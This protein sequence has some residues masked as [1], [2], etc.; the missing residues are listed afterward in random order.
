[1]C[2]C[3]CVCVCVCMYIYI[4]MSSFFFHLTHPKCGSLSIQVYI[5]DN[6]FL[7]KHYEIML[8]KMLNIHDWNQYASCSVSLFKYHSNV[9]GRSGDIWPLVSLC[10]SCPLSFRAQWDVCRLATGGGRVQP[11][12]LCLCV[13][14]CVW[15]R[16]RERERERDGT[17]EW[18]NRASV[19]RCRSCIL[20]HHYEP[21]DLHTQPRLSPKLHVHTDT[22][23]QRLEH[24]AGDTWSFHFGLVFIYAFIYLF[25]IIFFSKCII[26]NNYYF[27]EVAELKNT[28]WFAYGKH[29]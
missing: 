5:W 23:Q 6:L 12:V 21:T 17:V 29:A 11:S 10:L 20:H 9:N 4:Y 25:C 7:I 16:E 19:W 15:E 27:T 13:C 8:S 1:M 18:V 24:P 22:T 14:V 28:D 3:V 26:F 2:V